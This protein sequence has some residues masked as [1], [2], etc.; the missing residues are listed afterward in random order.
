M[1]QIKTREDYVFGAS[2]FHFHK[3]RNRLCGV[4]SKGRIIASEAV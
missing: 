1:G 4:L 3:R 2:E